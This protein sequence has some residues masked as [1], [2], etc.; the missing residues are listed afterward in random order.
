MLPAVSPIVFWVFEA[1]TTISSRFVAAA[2]SVIIDI[3]KTK[4]SLKAIEI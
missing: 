1:T 4:T 2:Q 3:K